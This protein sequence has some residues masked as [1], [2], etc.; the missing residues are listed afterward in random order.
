MEKIKKGVSQ[1]WDL[2]CPITKPSRSSKYAAGPAQQLQRRYSGPAR[3]E[4]DRKRY[5]GKVQGHYTLRLR[6]KETL[7]GYRFHS[8]YKAQTPSNRVQP[9]YPKTSNPESEWFFNYSIVNAY[10][11]TEDS[12]DKVKEDFHDALEKA[13]DACP[14]N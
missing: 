7:F 8:T 3:N 10:A 9:N 5:F 12:E 13:Y 2:E 11:S 14:E 1:H 4:M 6:Q